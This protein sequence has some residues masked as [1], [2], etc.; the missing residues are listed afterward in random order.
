[1]HSEYIK[2]QLPRGETQGLI[3]DSDGTTARNSDEL[4]QNYNI[5]L[6]PVELDSQSGIGINK[7]VPYS[8][9]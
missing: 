9:N 1:V 7:R 2:P 5:S 6:L 8:K 4:D 3:Y